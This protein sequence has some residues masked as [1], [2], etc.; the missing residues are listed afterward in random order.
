ML[1]DDQHTTGVILRFP[2][3][4][5]LIIIAIALIG[6]ALLL[7]SNTISFHSDEAVVALM[8]RHINAGARPVFFYGQA[9]MGSLDA[10]I[11]ALGYRLLGESVLSVR[12]VQSGLYLLVVAT[13]YLA[14]WRL[15]EKRTVAAVASLM[16][17]IPAVN[18]ALYTTATLG[19]YNETLLF[20][21]LILLLSYEVTHGQ[22][23]SAWRWGLLGLVAGLGWWTNGLIVMTVAPAGLM[24]LWVW[25]RTRR[26][27]TLP[28]LALALAAFFI[29]SAPWWIFDFTH[30]HAALATYLTNRQ[31]GTFEGIGIP[32]V[33]P[34]QRALGLLLIGI[35][36]LIGLRFPWSD[37]YFL[38]PLGV[39][40]LLLYVVAGWRF[41]RGKTVLKPGARLL[42][43]LLLLVFTI[44][45]V[46]STF[47]AD[48]TGRYFL[49]LLLPLG[50]LLGALVEVLRGQ[51]SPQSPLMRYAPWGL[52][53][54]VIVYH[55]LGQVAA[56]TSPTGFTAQ[57]DL[58]SH[59]TND[60]DAELVTFLQD[61]EL[62]TGHTNYWVAF[63]LAFLSG[64]RLQYSASLPYKE[65]LS[66]NAA[67]NRY[68]PYAEAA[69][70][71][72]RLAVITTKL[73]ALDQQLIATFDDQGLTYTQTEIGDYR[74]Y[75]DFTPTLP[76]V[77]F[78]TQADSS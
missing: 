73:P 68:L 15:S 28:L 36:A 25:Y 24:L 54:V 47:G 4:D 20:G 46:A 3:R 1:N 55:S 6:R 67:D 66:Y 7:A 37:S 11:I 35:P 70:S 57:F 45:F 44:I 38:L 52:V 41:I 30:D 5:F 18:T 72:E 2:W 75:Y 14:A 26:L 71:A 76:Q 9:Y 17:A 34:S 21:H 58:I 50:I 62:Y 33:P 32:Y 63:R 13:G 48:P 74:I 51:L 53:A 56:A 29:G 69:N 16:L 49:P 43:G 78:D 23:R 39:I 19:G 22:E 77:G 10:G 61:N 42:I 64:E 60:H 59:I 40:V 65:N 8:A 31:S 12:I 27:P